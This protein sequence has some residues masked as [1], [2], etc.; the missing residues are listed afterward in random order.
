MTRGPK[1]QT[2]ST[3]SRSGAGAIKERMRREDPSES[4]GGWKIKVSGINDENQCEGEG[5]A[6][7]GQREQQ[8]RTDRLLEHRRER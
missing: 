4:T 5:D 8:P 2:A 3:I 1:A 7:L 6:N